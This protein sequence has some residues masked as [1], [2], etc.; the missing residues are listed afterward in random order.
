ML[1]ESSSWGTLGG[2]AGTWLGGDLHT[3]A[4][5]GYLSLNLQHYGIGEDSA[6][7]QNPV[8]FN[9]R[10]AVAGASAAMRISDGFVRRITA[11]RKHEW[12]CTGTSLP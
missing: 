11:S 1:T 4:G 7:S 3:M 10:A 8:A 5:A 6:L 12:S 9:L 2:Y